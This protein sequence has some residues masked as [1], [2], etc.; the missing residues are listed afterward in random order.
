MHGGLR[1]IWVGPPM[2][3]IR[4]D[5]IAIAL[6]EIAEAPAA[7]LAVLGGMPDKYRPSAAFRWPI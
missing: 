1:L 5:H 4:L 3:P 6:P 2:P 7:L